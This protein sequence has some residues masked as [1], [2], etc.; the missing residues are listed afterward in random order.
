MHF[1]LAG[2]TVSYVHTDVTALESDGVARLTVAISMP[3]GVVSIETFFS[4]IVNTL[5]A[6]ATGLP[7]ASYMTLRLIAKCS[8]V[9]CARAPQFT[10]RC[11]KQE[12][13]LA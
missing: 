7:I 2:I 13:S 11:T 1:L 5:D 8:E 4:L 9:E 10:Q 3:P 12:A 6:T